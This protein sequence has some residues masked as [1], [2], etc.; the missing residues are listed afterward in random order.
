MTEDDDLIL[1]QPGGEGWAELCVGCHTNGARAT[2]QQMEA[3]RLALWTLTQEYQPTTI[4]QIFYQ[5]TVHGIVPKTEAGYDQIQRC[6]VELRLDHGTPFSWLAD[7]TRWQRKPRTHESLE[8]MLRI[9]A[10]TYRRAVWAEA[11]CHVEVW[12][13]K[14]ALSS[15][16]IPVTSELDVGLMVSRGYASLTFLYGA[17]EQIDALGKP[18]FIYHF[19]DWDPSGQDAANNI[20]RR[21]REFAPDAEIYFQKIAVTP[22]QIAQWSLPTRPTKASDS[23]SV[24]W[25]GGDSVELDAI[26]PNRL[27][28]LVRDCIEQHVAPRQL[29]ITRA[30]EESERELLRAWR[31][32]ERPAP[33]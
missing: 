31:P 9:S 23:R 2:Q 33:P 1:V 5:A 29:E 14:D 25:A 21:L 28:N 24:R 27:R 12:I 13:E 10:E 19:G 16:L 4:R 11:D 15:V 22:A 3:R 18:A 20:E 32:S 6:L 30:A 8:Q 17:A 7:F 26:D